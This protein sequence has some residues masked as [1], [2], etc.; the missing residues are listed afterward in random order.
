MML[1]PKIFG[2]ISIKKNFERKYDAK[3]RMQKELKSLDFN[4]FYTMY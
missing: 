4:Y 2:N 3:I 1:V